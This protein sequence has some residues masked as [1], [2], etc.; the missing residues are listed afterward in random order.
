MTKA[1]VAAT[2]IETGIIT[3]ENTSK[4]MNKSKMLKPLEKLM[5]ELDNEFYLSCKGKKISCI[6]HN[7]CI[8]PTNVRVLAKDVTTFVQEI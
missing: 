6:L 3:N 7:G 5:R 2:L 4:V 8:D 1:V